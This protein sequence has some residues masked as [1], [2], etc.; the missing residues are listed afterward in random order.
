MSEMGNGLHKRNLERDAAAS[1]NEA[2]SPAQIGEILSRGAY[3]CAVCGAT[4][5]EGVELQVS[6]IKPRS[7]GGASS[8]ENGQALC[9]AHSR[10]ENACDQTDSGRRMFANL[11]R[12]AS[13]ENDQ[14]MLDFVDDALRVYEEHGVNDRIEW[15]S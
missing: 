15:K 5:A 6:H 12:M 7:R 9:A 11:R 4:Q 1:E 13:E 14:A 10:G 8:V 3:R 2:F